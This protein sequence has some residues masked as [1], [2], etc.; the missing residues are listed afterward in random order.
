MPPPK[1]G[2]EPSSF[3]STAGDAMSLGTT[4]ALCAIIPF[5]VGKW[6]GER[7]GHADAG[8]IAGLALGV[9]A[10]GVELARTVKRLNR[11]SRASDAKERPRDDDASDGR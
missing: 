10:A 9:A 2:G 3:W 5:V 4:L 6:V 8:A 1:R 11:S 7:Y